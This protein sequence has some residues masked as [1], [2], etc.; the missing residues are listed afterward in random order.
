MEEK[1][2]LLVDSANPYGAPAFD[3]IE[4]KHYKPA[5]EKS[6]A[7]ARADVDAIIANQD[8]PTFENTILA[9]ENAGKTYNSVSEIFFNLNECCTNDQMQNLA[10]ELTPMMTEYSMYVLFNPVLFSKIKS[11]YEKRDGLGLDK[12]QMRLLTETYKSVEENGAN[13]NDEQKVEFAKIAEELSLATLQFGKN[14][15]AATNA[16]TLNLT[17]E[18]DLEGL[19]AYVIEMGAEEAKARGEKGWTYTLNQSSYSDFIMFS[20]RRDLREKMW[21]EYNGKCIGGEHDNNELIHKI[22]TLR[23]REAALLGYNTYADFALH[24]RM[25]KNQETVNNFISDLMTKSLPFARADVAAISAFAR[26]TG[27]EGEFMPWD[28]SYWSEKYKN[29]KYSLSQEMLKPYFELGSVR[30]AVLGL[31]TTL[32]G[33]T[34]E[35]RND[36]PVYHPDVTVYEVK[37]GDRFMGLLYFDFFPRDSKQGGAWMTSFREESVE[38]G[39][40]KRPFVSIVTNF[41]KPTSTTPSL[42]TFYE[43][44]TILHEFGHGLHGLLAEGSYASLTGTNVTRDFIELPS[45]IM[46]NWAYEPEFL[47]SF[48]KHYKTGEVIPQ[49]YIDRIIAAKNYNAGYSSVRQL[50]FGTIDMAWHSNT[51]TPSDNAVDFEHKV[52]ARTAVVPMIDGIAMC[53]SFT[54]IFAGGYAAG[55]YS[56]KWAEVLDAD[57]FSLFKE[58]GIFNK[59]VAASFRENILS[60]GNVEDADV[61]FRNFRGRDPRPEA[62]LERS[63]MIK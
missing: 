51:E 21:R 60:K 55:Y 7:M 53:P 15:L 32:Y 57:A 47:Q 13:L 4:L 12:E 17:D 11:V 36:I 59:E 35:E 8:E 3:K 9:L 45:Q 49:E 24:N 27:F 63:G 28:F 19:P 14:V 16:F 10:E 30:K 41:T 40:E 48:A 26:E 33:I 34:F 20:A 52:L 37:D 22:V 25:A 38:N 44:T 23:T 58:K 56:Y 39:V 61:L 46:E 29:E 6:I 50:Q 2:P 18:A 31:A 42:L 54:H 5:F 62:L 43:V 1:N